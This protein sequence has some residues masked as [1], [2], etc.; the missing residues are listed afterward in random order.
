MTVPEA[1][2]MLLPLA[3]AHALLNP[4]RPSRLAALK[5]EMDAMLNNGFPEITENGAREKVFS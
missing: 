2:D 1:G 5:R 3:P 4:Q